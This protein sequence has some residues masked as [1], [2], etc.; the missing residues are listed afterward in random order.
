MQSSLNS[1]IRI[2]AKTKH[3][4]SQQNIDILQASIHFLFV[5]KTRGG[6]SVRLKNSVSVFGFRLVRSLETQDRISS[7]KSQDRQIRSRFFGLGL[8]LTNFFS[9]PLESGDGGNGDDAGG[10]RQRRWSLEGARAEG[11]GGGGQRW[12]RRRRWRRHRCRCQ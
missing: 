11:G 1:R 3:I 10:G 6:R 4:F 8:G 5:P 9:H 2:E 12:R 7:K